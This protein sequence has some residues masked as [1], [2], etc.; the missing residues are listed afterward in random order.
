[1]IVKD[2]RGKTVGMINVSSCR[3][4]A[5]TEG[6]IKL[7]YTI[8]NQASNAIERLQ[9]VIIAEKSKM[10]SMVE[11]MAEG[12][13]MID[14]RGDVVVSNPRAKEML[15]FG[16]SEEITSRMLIE[17][18]NVIGLYDAFQEC[19][20]KQS[21]ITKEIVIS[22]PGREVF[23]RCDMAPVK[24]IEG[25]IIGFVTVLRDISKEKEVDTMKTEFISTVSH[26]IRTPLSIVKEGLGLVLDKTA[27]EISEEQEHFL[28]LSKNNI[29][30]LENI[31]NG[32]LDISKI[33]ADKVELRMG[34]TNMTELIRQTV[35]SFEIRVKE[36]GLELKANLPKEVIDVYADS[37]KIIQVFVNLINN[38]LKFTEKGFIEISACDKKDVV[39][40]SVS[41]TGRGISRE[42]LPKVFRKFQQFDRVRGGAGEKGTGLGLSIAKGIIELHHGKIWVESEFNKG[43]KFTFTLPKRSSEM[44]FKQYVNNGIKNAMERNTKMSLI[45]V[46][47]A[48]F[49]ELKQ[50]LSKEEIKSIL[51]DVEGNLKNSLRREGNVV[52]KN[53][54]ET[55]VILTDC[56]RENAL[57]VEGRLEQSLE[58]YLRTKN[59]TKDIVLRFGLATYPDDAKE[60]EGLIS[61]AKKTL[62]E[63]RG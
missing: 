2:V 58:D 51:K 42:D 50:K 62:G 47:I 46:S 21:L 25:G 44:I 1:M 37:E 30:R 41:D 24:D 33:E 45:V 38:A 17:K 43:T 36:R 20:D 15:G 28:T 29:D 63:D 19:Q 9:A 14:V 23:L 10:E 53:T 5:F 27:C 3:D 18:L 55:I 54:G 31:I 52:V 7:I 4:D 35:D 56:D 6:N 60:D 12:V 22:V 26:E 34:L 32:L 11:S 13:V 61:K 8:A 40:F 39:E 59:Q 57:R 48:K 16:L 49:D